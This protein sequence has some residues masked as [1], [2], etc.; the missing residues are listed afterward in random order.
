MIEKF[1]GESRPVG[2]W[3]EEMQF[4]RSHWGIG[5][6]L[7]MAFVIESWEM[8]II[9]LNSSSIAAEFSLDTSQLGTLIGAIFLGMIPGALIWGRLTDILGRKKCVILSLALYAPLP[10]MSAFTTSYEML[11]V[12]RF[13]CGIILSGLLVTTF[14]LFEE[15]VPVKIRGRATVCLSAGWPVGL[16]VA[17]G[18]TS[19]FLGSSW[20]LVLGFSSLAGLWAFA[21]YK[22]VPES[23]YWLAEKGRVD[24]AEDVIHR[25][26]E[27]G[28]TA[29]ILLRN[30]T[31]DPEGKDSFFNIF[32]GTVARITL[33]QTVINFC[34]SWGYWGLASWMPVLLAKKG[35]NTPDGLSFMAISA[36]FMFPGY[37]AASYLTGR[38]G[39]KKVMVVFVFISTCAGFGFANSSTVEEM[40][41]WNFMLS[42][43]SLGAWGVWNTW[44]GEIYA[45]ETR[46]AGFAWGIMIQRVANSLAPLVIGAMLVSASFLQTVVFISTFLAISFMAAI[47]LPETEG[48]T[49]A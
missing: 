20:R 39:R 25:L 19:L 13:F 22:L 7:F 34:F 48:K 29:S 41:F 15:L 27:G 14:P 38:L 3:F 37:I 45:T 5:F 32:R 30:G 23:P 33:I 4:T 28:L 26:S 42:F 31:S 36:L 16:L 21:V 6:A 1:S 8:M 12:V 10:I 40:Y 49:L 35:L 44:M 47:F 43:F 17:I 2:E 24:E 46:S 18:I 9:I 11:I